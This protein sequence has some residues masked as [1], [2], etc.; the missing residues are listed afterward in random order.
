MLLSAALLPLMLAL[1]VGASL[2]ADV[3]VVLL[4]V[5]VS[6]ALELPLTGRARGKTAIMLCCGGVNVV[7]A[8]GAFRSDVRKIHLLGR[9]THSLSSAEDR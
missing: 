6:A 4:V 3:V 2:E 5:V 8:C 7:L 1:V 9:E